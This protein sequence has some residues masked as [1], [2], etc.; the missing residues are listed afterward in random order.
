[1]VTFQ[2]DACYLIPVVQQAVLSVKFYIIQ[3]CFQVKRLWAYPKNNQISV[4]FNETAGKK[5]GTQAAIGEACLALKHSFCPPTPEAA[6][7]L[8]ILIAVVGSI[9]RNCAQLLPVAAQ[10]LWG[11][12][13]LQKQRRKS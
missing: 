1:M 3:A 2:L 9:T 10:S 8:P 12:L 5:Q 6:Q 11:K 4:P 7:G 13:V